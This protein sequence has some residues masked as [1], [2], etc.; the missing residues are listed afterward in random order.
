M[1]RV[2]ILAAG[3]LLTIGLV[4]SAELRSVARAA[5]QAASKQEAVA[6]KA[7][8]PD[9]AKLL[10]KFP[11][12]DVNHDGVLTDQELKDGRARIRDAR[13]LKVDNFKPDA[14]MF[15]WLIEHLAEMDLDRNAQL[16]RDELLRARDQYGAMNRAAAAKPEAILKQFPE[17]DTNGDGTLSRE[18]YKALTSANPAAA[19]LIFLQRHPQADTNGD[20]TLSDEEYQAAQ[21]KAKPDAKA[22]KNPAKKKN[23]NAEAGDSAQP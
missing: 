12:M 22:V 7:A 18:E 13:G 20:G 21:G 16:S 3:L 19:K 2:T 23:R 11:E 14:R 6:Q 8:G 9:R 17:A 1:S 10:Q 5:D 15:N 4:A